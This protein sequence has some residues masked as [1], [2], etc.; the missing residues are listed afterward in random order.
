[1]SHQSLLY[2]LIRVLPC[3]PR[4]ESPSEDSS[5]AENSEHESTENE[6]PEPPARVLSPAECPQLRPPGAAVAT[7]SLEGPQLSQ[8]SQRVPAPEVASGPDPE[9]EIRSVLWVGW[10]RRVSLICCCLGS[11]HAGFLS[12][13]HSHS[14]WDKQHLTFSISHDLLNVFLSF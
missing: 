3:P 4:Y 12:V 7:T 14:L 11:G 10:H 2:P 9:E 5:T 6:G 13:G 1:M 8:E